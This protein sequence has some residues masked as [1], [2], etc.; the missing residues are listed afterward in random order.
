[1]AQ[2]LLVVLLTSACGGVYLC[3][4]LLG[5]LFDEVHVVLAVLLYGAQ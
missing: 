3:M 5:A 1:M 2:I 4:L